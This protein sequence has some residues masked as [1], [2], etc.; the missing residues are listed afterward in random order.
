MPLQWSCTWPVTPYLAIRSNSKPSLDA[1][2]WECTTIQRAPNFP[3]YLPCGDAYRRQAFRQL[4]SS[5]TLTLPNQ[6]AYQP[7]NRHGIAHAID[8][9]DSPDTLAYDVHVN[10]FN[11]S[12]ATGCTNAST[13][14]VD[15]NRRTVGVGSFVEFTIPFRAA[16]LNKFGQMSSSDFDLHTLLY[17]H[18]DSVQFIV[19]VQVVEKTAADDN[20]NNTTTG[21]TAAVVNDAT[22]QFSL[23]HVGFASNA[24]TSCKHGGEKAIQQ[25]YLIEVDNVVEG[26]TSGPRF[27]SD[28]ALVSPCHSVTP[29][30]L[31]SLGCSNGS[32]AYYLVTRTECRSTSRTT[33]NNTWAPCQDKGRNGS[34]VLHSTIL[35]QLWTCVGKLSRAKFSSHF[36]DDSSLCIT[37][38][39]RYAQSSV[40]IDEDALWVNKAVR[41]DIN[42]VL[43]RTPE[44]PLSDVL[45]KEPLSN[46][47]PG[48]V[49]SL[50]MPV[51][52][53]LTE[54]ALTVAVFFDNAVS[55]TVLDLSIVP[56]SIALIGVDSLGRDVEPKL[57]LPQVLHTLSALPKQLTPNQDLRLPACKPYAGCDGFVARTRQLQAI[58]PSAVFYRVELSVQLNS[59]VNG[60]SP[61]NSST[62]EPSGKHDPAARRLLQ[63]A[64]GDYDYD[65]G[66][67]ITEI[68]TSTKVGNTTVNETII[69]ITDGDI[70]IIDIEITNGT[71]HVFAEIIIDT[72]ELDAI[73]RRSRATDVLV[74][75]FFVVLGLAL[76]GVCICVAYFWLGQA[77]TSSTS[78]PFALTG[79]KQSLDLYGVAGRANL[80]NMPPRIIVTTRAGGYQRLPTTEM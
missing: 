6:T 73:D 1:Q 30:R 18:R 67:T 37:R 54:T 76:F 69:I 16:W 77:N 24:S 29:V 63:D 51:R 80:H 56:E 43:L 65:S 3:T 12:I 39:V 15:Y 28:I 4:A 50:P 38:G 7:L 57:T 20:N 35:V 25:I 40:A 55:R 44:S 11:H 27:L 58:L 5:H 66:E 52:A 46:V 62:P 68:D 64:D 49:T 78:Q 53:V 75:V 21:S 71:S 26:T 34:L 72:S 36:E 59:G 8:F 48:D 2:K 74:I 79:S 33:H 41:F 13:A 60:S 14:L 10:L 61:A 9:L 45:Q 31:V 32:C 17:G 47:V 42:M 70:T 19:P 23:V 22:V